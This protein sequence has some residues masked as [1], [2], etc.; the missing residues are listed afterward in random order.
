MNFLLKKFFVLELLFSRT[1]VMKLPFLKLIPKEV[2][3]SLFFAGIALLSFV[4]Y[5]T[6]Q[7]KTKNIQQKVQGIKTTITQSPSSAQKVPRQ[8]I[9]VTKA[10]DSSDGEEEIKTQTIEITIAIT[11]T[12]KSS[13]DKA[14]IHVSIDGASSF[15]LE[16][17]KGK[18]QCEVLQQALQDNKISQLLM[19][20][21][22]SLDSTGIYQINGIGKENAV[23][24][25]YEVNGKAPTS[26]CNHIAAN[27]DDRVFWKYVGQR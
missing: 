7:E 23:W 15:S 3:F 16:L 6:P 17:D 11:P 1:N 21:D 20:Y 18:N 14:T 25:T 27:H 19:K 26:G 8:T 13:S 5:F 9:L 10:Q 22:N 24:W 12:P 2:F 4:L